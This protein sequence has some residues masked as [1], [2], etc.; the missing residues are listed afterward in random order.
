MFF[1]DFCKKFEIMLSFTGIFIATFKKVSIFL[2]LA[3][4]IENRIIE[5]TCTSLTDILIVSWENCEKFSKSI[6]SGRKTIDFNSVFSEKQNA[7]ERQNKILTMLTKSHILLIEKVFFVYR[8]QKN[9]ERL[10]KN[11]RNLNNF[12]DM[13]ELTAISWLFDSFS[14]D[15]F[16][17]SKTVFCNKV[18]PRWHQL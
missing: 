1:V 7:T 9:P 5:V 2:R 18:C 12:H 15:N 10:W 8:W 17:C 6:K 16:L 4:W 11:S 3:I 13:L 14:S